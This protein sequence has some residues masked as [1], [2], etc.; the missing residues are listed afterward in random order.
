MPAACLILYQ[1]T[2][3]PRKKAWRE[4]PPAR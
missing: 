1:R 2:L 4:L 3:S